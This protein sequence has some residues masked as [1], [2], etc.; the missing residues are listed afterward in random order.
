MAGQKRKRSSTS[1]KASRD[2]PE[3]VT[4]SI[5][6]A[7]EPVPDSAEIPWTL[8]SKRRKT[9]RATLGETGTNEIPELGDLGKS[10]DYTVKW[11]MK[12]HPKVAWTDIQHYKRY[13][14]TWSL[15]AQMG[16]L[17]LSSEA[18]H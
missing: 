2:A 8:V 10:L 17:Y 14:C 11:M 9:G 1:A 5:E 18:K 13:K 12:I 4:L 16:A 3:D 6:E 7:A 15:S